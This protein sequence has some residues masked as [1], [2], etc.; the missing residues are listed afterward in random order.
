MIG[1]IAN[2]PSGSVG[3]VRIALRKDCEPDVMYVKD[4][5]SEPFSGGAIIERWQ[6]DAVCFHDMAGRTI[7]T[8]LANCV[9]IRY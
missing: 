3:E 5:L 8:S 4:F 1:R 9:V 7:T 6:T 2:A